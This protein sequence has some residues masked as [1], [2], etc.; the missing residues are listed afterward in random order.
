MKKIQQTRRRE[1]E[2]FLLLCR[3][4]PG[5]DRWVDGEGVYFESQGSCME[6]ATSPPIKSLPPPFSSHP[7]CRLFFT[8]SLSLLLFQ[9]FS[10]YSDAAHSRFW[11]SFWETGSRNIS[12]YTTHQTMNGSPKEKSSSPTH[13]PATSSSFPC[14]FWGC[15][16]D[17]PAATNI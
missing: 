11:S 1:E 9:F 5:G 13:T 15:C 2:H 4:I 3:K 14:S 12:N 17:E 7:P 10:L 8:P 6:V 16:L